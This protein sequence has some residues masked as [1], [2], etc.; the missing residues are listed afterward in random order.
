[1]FISP[2]QS[3]LICLHVVVA[4]TKMRLSGAYVELTAILFI[5]SNSS[6]VYFF[7]PLDRHLKILFQLDE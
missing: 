7:V 2:K 1:M 5:D 3:P 6:L 4:A